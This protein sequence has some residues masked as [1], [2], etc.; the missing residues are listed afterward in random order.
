MSNTVRD[1]VLV[2][3]SGF[4]SAV[5]GGGFTAWLTLKSRNS[6]L[7]AEA[8][9]IKWS[10]WEDA[11]RLLQSDV[12]K[13]RARVDALEKDLEKR[14]DQ[15]RE[16]DSYIALLLDGI[17]KLLSQIREAC[18]TPVWCPPSPPWQEDEDEI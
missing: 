7:N 12:E 15:L 3:V 2:L 10:T 17:R 13:L 8:G 16:R 9:K 14:K 11:Y 18:L 1:I 6:K 5:A 4:F